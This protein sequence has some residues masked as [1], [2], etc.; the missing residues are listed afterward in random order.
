MEWLIGILALAWLIFMLV[1]CARAFFSV[2]K[3]IGKE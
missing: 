1:M 3:A 2:G